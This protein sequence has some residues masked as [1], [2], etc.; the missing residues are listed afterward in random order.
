LPSEEEVASLVGAD[1][2][3]LLVELE[4]I[5]RMVQAAKLRVIDHADREARFLADGHRNSA[6]WTRA[7]TNCS[8]AESRKRVRAARALRD[9]PSIR[10][11]LRQGTVGVDQVDEVAHTDWDAARTHH[12]DASPPACCRAPPPNAAS[13]PSSRCSKRAPPIPPTR[14]RPIRS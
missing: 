5:G 1:H 3:Q 9:L 14:H 2:D 7:V 8:P 6:A 12:G 10:A 11:A 4:R 13:T